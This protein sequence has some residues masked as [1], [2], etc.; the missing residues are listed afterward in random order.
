LGFP[1]IVHLILRILVDSII[2]SCTVYDS[3]SM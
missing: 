2:I 3:Q 1:V